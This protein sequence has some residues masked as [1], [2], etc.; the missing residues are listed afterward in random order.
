MDTQLTII[1][2]KIYEIRGQKVMLDFDLAEMYQVETRVLNQSV[3][4][5]I[6]R[7]PE[8]FMFQMTSEEWSDM[9]SQFVMTSRL[10]RPKTALPLAFTEHGVVMLSSVLKSE[11][12]VQTSVLIVRAFVGIRQLISQSPVDRV[13]QLENRVKELKDYIEEVFADY[14]DINDDTRMQLE[15]INQTLV[16]LQTQKKLAEKPR[17]PIGFKK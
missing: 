17:N 11:I 3:K 4:R 6:Q 13:G 10:K 2:S 15:L 5:N 8:D 14:N 12:A 7:F 16:E 9:S 1:Q